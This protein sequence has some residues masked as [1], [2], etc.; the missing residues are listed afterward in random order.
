MSQY[1]SYTKEGPVPCV[2]GYAEVIP[3]DKNNTFACSNV[4][5]AHPLLLKQDITD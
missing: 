1:K 3:G 4:S 2:D 5:L